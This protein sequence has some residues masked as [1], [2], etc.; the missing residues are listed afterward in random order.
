MFMPCPFDITMATNSVRLNAKRQG[1][2]AFTVFNRSGRPVRGRVQ[3]APQDPSTTAWFTVT[4][5]SERAFAI[6]GT[7][8]F[9]V[10]ISVP[11]K[12]AAGSYALRLDMVGV[13]NPDEDYCAGPS[14]TLEVP[15]P[16]PVKPFPWKW[17]VI[18]AVVL[19]G[20]G[21]AAFLLWPRNV[22]VPPL[23]GLTVNDARATLEA[24][25]LLP[26]TLQEGVGTESDAGKILAS[27]PEAGVSVAR[28]S[29]VDLVVGAASTPT[30]AA[31]ATFTPSP[32]PTPDLAAT[33]TAEALAVAAATATAV[34]QAIGKYVGTWEVSDDASPYIT[35]LTVTRTDQTVT[36]A[37]AGRAFI[38]VTNGG[39]ASGTCVQGTE[40][41]WGSASVEYTGDPLQFT[42]SSGNGATQQLTLASIDQNTLSAVHRVQGG[43]TSLPE[44]VT[45]LKRARFN[46]VL[47]AVLDPAVRAENVLPYVILTPV[48]EEFLVAPRFEIERWTP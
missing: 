47:D 11:D 32:T 29:A 33:A 15:E 34:T 4:G 35:K 36:V 3:L 12:A 10:Q 9:T 8:Q 37:V 43:G 6:A 14:V 31:T 20:V 48:P 22:Q 16:A 39:L 19:L 18:A 30:P 42:I 2:A 44:M 24:V 7:E 46:P 28:D 17:I 40:C 27:T 13:E 45:L 41:T 23:Q 25:R 5:E 38:L 21:V 1:E 26:G